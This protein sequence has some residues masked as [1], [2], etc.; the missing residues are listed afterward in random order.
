MYYMHRNVNTMYINASYTHSYMYIGTIV[1]VLTCTVS[2]TGT[3]PNMEVSYIYI[4]Y[5][6]LNAY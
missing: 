3:A 6:C 5:R 2:N 1:Y 4:Y